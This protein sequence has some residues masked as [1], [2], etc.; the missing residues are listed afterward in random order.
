MLELTVQDSSEWPTGTRRF[1]S[2]SDGRFYVDVPR[3]RKRWT[4]PAGVE[5]LRY[6]RSHGNPGAAREHYA[7]EHTAKEVAR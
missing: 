2:G 1:A 7:C 3:R 6:W 5:H 4:C